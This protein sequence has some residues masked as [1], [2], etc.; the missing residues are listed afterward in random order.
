MG[1]K[2]T[3]TP[4][5]KTADLPTEQFAKIRKRFESDDYDL[6]DVMLRAYYLGKE[7]TQQQ[8]IAT[9]EKWV[10]LE[11][12]LPEKSG[13]YIIHAKFTADCPFAVYEAR[14]SDKNKQFYS[15]AIKSKKVTHWQPLPQ[16]PTKVKGE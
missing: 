13:D 6:T 12:G 2:T 4:A 16:P 15:N 8:A 3:T 1:N 14:Y 5:V 9:G 7:A 11:T 10:S